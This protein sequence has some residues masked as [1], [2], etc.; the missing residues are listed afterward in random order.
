MMIKS[1][2]SA[3]KKQTA[4]AQLATRT[5][6]T[7]PNTGAHIPD[8]MEDV[9]DFMDREKPTITCVYFH[10]SWNPICKEIEKDYLNAVKA[11]PNVT[12]L[13]VDCDKAPRIKKYFDARVEPQFLILLN[14]GEL[15]RIVG[16]NFDKVYAQLEKASD[17]HYRDFNYYGDTANTFERMYDH[18]DRWARSMEHDRDA[19]RFQKDVQNDTHR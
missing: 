17:L 5:M 4:L 8:D 6:V 19:F 16:F 1:A 13:M 10:A 15:S 18:H 2:L 12:H 7:C 11:F 14:G 3:L 9:I